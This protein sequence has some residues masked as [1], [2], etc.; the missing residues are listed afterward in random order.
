MK[1]DDYK[2]LREIEAIAPNNDFIQ[3]IT[4]RVSSNDYRGM[5]CSQHN[6]LTY[7]Y[8]SNLISVIYS[9]A[10]DGIF[11]IHIGDDKGVKQ[12]WANTYY[13]VVMAIKQIEGKGTIN[14][15][16]ST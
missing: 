6:R 1:L 7:S 11:S 10:G 3:Y 12:P 8:F 5:Q 2:Y 13:E 9:I 15:N 14:S 4:T 16:I